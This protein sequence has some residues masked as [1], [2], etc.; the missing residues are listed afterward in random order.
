MLTHL[1]SAI[2][3]SYANSS[4]IRKIIRLRFKVSLMSWIVQ[5]GAWAVVKFGYKKKCLRVLQ[6][7]RTQPG[8]AHLNSE[9]VSIN[10]SNLLDLLTGYD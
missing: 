8:S 7:S 1:E 10:M 5:S 6:R 9:G 2:S 4:S 3:T